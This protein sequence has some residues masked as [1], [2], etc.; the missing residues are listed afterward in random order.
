MNGAPRYAARCTF[1]RMTL[2]SKRVG[3]VVNICH[4]GARE[5]ME[6]VGP[7]MDDFETACGFWEL[8]AGTAASPVF[9]HEDTRLREL[10]RTEYAPWARR[11][12]Q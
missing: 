12:E 2:D 5:D 10:P 9:G 6:C 3:G 7:F 1:V 8:K 11:R 4:H